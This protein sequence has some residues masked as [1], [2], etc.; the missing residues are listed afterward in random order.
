[1]LYEICTGFGIPKT[2]VHVCMKYPVIFIGGNINFLFIKGYT[3]PLLFN[4]GLEYA[5][6][7]ENQE[8]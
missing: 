7:K 8:V 5:I 4:Y 6:R 2:F 1:M 3:I